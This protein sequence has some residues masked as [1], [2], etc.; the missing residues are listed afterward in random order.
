MRFEININN[1]NSAVID[2]L[3]NSIN[4][5]LSILGNRL[6]SNSRHL[7]QAKTLQVVGVIAY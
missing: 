3:T 4:V 5:R 1:K 7:Y 2:G 6:K